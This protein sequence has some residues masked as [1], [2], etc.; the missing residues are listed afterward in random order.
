MHVADDV[1]WSVLVLQVG[2]QRRPFDGDLFHLFRRVKDEDVPKALSP[3]P[4]Q[5][6]P[7]LLRLP[8]HYSRPER[9][10]GS[11]LVPGQAY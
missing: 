9:P 6:P 5:R 4:P 2:P 1:E 8:A 7:K 3:Q 11:S 10:V